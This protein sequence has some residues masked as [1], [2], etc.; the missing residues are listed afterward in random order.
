MI[1]FHKSIIYP[2]DDELD[3]DIPLKNKAG[4][5]HE[6]DTHIFVG[7]CGV[8]GTQNDV[9]LR[10]WD[11]YFYIDDNDK[12]HFEA[13]INMGNKDITGVNKITT[14][15]LNVNGQIDMKGNKIIGVGN[16]TANSDAVNKTQLDTPETQINS[17]VSI[18]DNKIIQ[19]KEEI[20]TI[21]N[22]LTKVKY[23]YFTDQLKHDNANTVKFPA[24]NSYPYSAVDNSE[25]LKIELDGHYQI[26]Y[27]DYH[28]KVFNL[29]FMMIQ[30]EIIYLLHIFT[31]IQI[32][33]QWQ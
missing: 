30:M 20:N 27:T 21:L 12:I 32:G 23:Y 4:E 18:V 19:I 13:P 8:A 14:G 29:S 2:S 3:V 28:K 15:D 24:I 31:I 33:Q 9:D 10:L 5:S 1:N 6:V 17:E 26:I 7:V 11:R 25:F 22:S 16:G